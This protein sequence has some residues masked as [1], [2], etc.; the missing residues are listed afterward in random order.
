MRDRLRVIVAD[1]ERP[2]RSVLVS[3]LR[4]FDDVEIVGEAV[5]GTTAVEL[6]ER[7]KPDLALLDLQM[8]EVDGIGVVRL[9][10]RSSIPM[11]AFVTAYDAYA[12]R[13]FELNAV[14]YLLKPVDAARLRETI[15]RAIDRLDRD[16]ARAASAKNLRSAVRA[17]DASSAVPLRRIPVRRKN[18]IVLVPVS[19]VASVIADGEL[20]HLTTVRGVKHTI[21]YRLKDLE[22]RLDHEEFVRLSR[23][24]LANISA[25]TKATP[26]PGGTFVL[27]LSNGQELQT[28]R[29]HSRLLRERLLRL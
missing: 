1:D 14:D 25:I 23:G 11:I 12:V 9:L 18:E 10:K 16:D 26:M 19:D 27:S 5:D 24:T 20:L 28:S 4:G 3:L 6:I 17:F 8:P 29:F 22:A 15:S 21:S 13:A 7:H 2:A